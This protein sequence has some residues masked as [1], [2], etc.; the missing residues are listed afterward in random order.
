MVAADRIDYL[1]YFVAAAA[2]EL[3][4]RLSLNIL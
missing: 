1:N 3:C 2:D 4:A